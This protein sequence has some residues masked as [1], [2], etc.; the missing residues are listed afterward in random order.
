MKRFFFFLVLAGLLLTSYAIYDYIRFDDLR[1]NRA[2]AKGDKTA[3]RVKKQLDSLTVLTKTSAELL[4]DKLSSNRFSLKEIQHLVKEEVLELN[5]IIGITVAYEPHAYTDDVRLTSLFYNGLSSQFLK[6]EDSYDYTDG[7]LP[8]A[9]WYTLCRDEQQ[10]IL[11][12]PYFG[13]AANELVIDYAVP[14]FNTTADGANEFIGVV[15]YTIA[16]DEFTEVVNSFIQGNSGYV[17]LTNSD[18]L[19]ITHPNRSYILNNRGLD[20][21]QSNSDED[22]V[23]K[24]ITNESG[25]VNYLSPYTGVPSILF[26]NTVAL[27][28]WKIAIVYSRTDLLGNPRQLEKKIIHIGLAVSFLLIAIVVLVFGWHEGLD[29]HLWGISSIVTF[30]MIANIAL[31]WVVHLD[32]DYSEELEKST[33]VYSNSA[34]SSFVDKKN[35]EQRLLGNQAYLEVPTGVFIQELEVTDSYNMSVSGKIWQKW[36]AGHDLKDNLGFE[37]LQASPTGRSVIVDLLSKDKLDDDTWLYTWKF[38]ATLRVFFDYNQYPLDQHCIDIKLIYPDLTENIM[39]VP[40]FGSYEVLNPAS[41]PGMSDIIFLPRH[42]IIA[43]YFSFS[44]MDMKT[45]FG[46][47]RTTTSSEYEALEYNIV[48][49]RRFITPFISF[50]I[51]FILGASIIFFLLYSLN[52]DQ[53]DN[54][55]VTVMGVVQGMAALFFSMLLA[56]ITIRNRIPSPIVTYLEA[57]YFII[58]IMIGLLI[59]LVVM[60]SRS[61]NYRLLNYRDNLVIKVT[62]W[63]I[64]ISLLYVITLMKFY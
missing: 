42:R 14:I 49:K 46:Q 7:T 51:P 43:S 11:T 22:L 25:H 53:N 32:I 19:I 12:N 48:I 1:V 4:A 13:R 16:P 10:P 61:N 47:N 3:L 45:F 50:I 18:G 38:N 54:S 26:F 37:F 21:Q 20:F 27:V 41:R 5:H 56:H 64:L 40:D 24:I 57:F 52:K 6:I 23:E 55:G 30:I 33:R 34:L 62:Y 9:K 59:M 35:Y 17:Y 8:T 31:I 36:P 58:Y 39:L 29:R 2:I 15:S 28:N 60:Y 44:S 63:P